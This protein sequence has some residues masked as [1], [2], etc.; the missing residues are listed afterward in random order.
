MT[1]CIA[2]ER[3]LVVATCPLRKGRCY[4]QHRETQICCYTSKD[5]EPHE[6]AELV[7]TEVPETDPQELFQK[8]QVELGK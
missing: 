3:E 2:I 4:W 6:Y 8:L 1:F 5:L 7:G